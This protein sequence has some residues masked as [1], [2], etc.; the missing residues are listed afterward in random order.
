MSQW[1]QTAST[2]GVGSQ[3]VI[4]SH[5]ST[6]GSDRYMDTYYR[7]DAGTL[8]IYTGEGGIKTARY[9]IT[10]SLNTWYKLRTE[11]DVTAGIY[12]IYLNGV[13]Q[14]SSTAPLPSGTAA[15]NGFAVAEFVGGGGFWWSGLE[16]EVRVTT[17]I[18]TANWET[19]EYNNQSDEPTFWGSWSTVGG[20][21]TPT[22]MMHMMQ[23]AGGLM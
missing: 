17:T 13:L 22:P 11:R 1:F 6:T 15:Q 10:L 19:T 20:G 7:N 18:P 4:V 2:P 14:A 21:F 8:S 16:D 3:P 9:I 12:R 23:M 5:R